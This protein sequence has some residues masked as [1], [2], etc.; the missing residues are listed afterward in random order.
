MIPSLSSFDPEYHLCVGDVY[1][2]QLL[3]E[4]ITGVCEVKSIKNRPISQR[5]NN[6]SGPHW[7]QVVP[8]IRLGCIP[9]SEK[10]KARTILHF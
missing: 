9:C 8:S 3:I 1:F 2:I 5:C 4:P 6:L 7:R 10:H